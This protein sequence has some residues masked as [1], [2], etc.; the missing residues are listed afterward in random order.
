VSW[1]ATRDSR[2]AWASTH[3][4]RGCGLEVGTA[5][6]DA[7]RLPPTFEETP[8]LVI[9]ADLDVD[10]T[11]ETLAIVG[12]HRVPEAASARMTGRV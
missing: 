10:A 7:G 1:G 2:A 3:G 6:C 5:A 12:A 9:T 8:R 11:P 4:K